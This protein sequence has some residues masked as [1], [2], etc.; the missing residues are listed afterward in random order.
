L[1][2]SNDNRDI[3]RGEVWK[4]LAVRAQKGDARAYAELLRDIIPFI[5]G[6]AAGSLANP[7]WI[8]DLVQDVLISVHKSLSTYSEDRPFR[9]WL[10]AIIQFRRTDLLRKYY[11]SR[12]NKSVG[13]EDADF[14]AQH[15]TNPAL[16][17]E[18]KDIEA[19]LADLPD[20]QR[21]VFELIKIQGYS[22]QEVADEMG[23]S[24]SA[25][26]VSAHRTMNKL[27]DRLG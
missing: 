23:M 21:K 25:V 22:A 17:G 24:V 4:D 3:S 5:K 15:V 18:L 11:K 2:L 16:S 14:Q 10:S 20:K 7:D 26:K 13:L 27:K 19:A 8:E 9:P 12:G 1:A 6:V